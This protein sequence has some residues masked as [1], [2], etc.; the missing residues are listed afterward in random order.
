MDGSGECERLFVRYELSV[1]RR[2][3]F[4]RGEWLLLR[5]LSA[6]RESDQHVKRER[7][8]RGRANSEAPEYDEPFEVMQETAAPPCAFMFHGRLFPSMPSH[9]RASLRAPDS[10]APRGLAEA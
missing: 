4:D 5:E 7:K 1:L 2:R 8:Q 3:G 10:G 6:H 9:V